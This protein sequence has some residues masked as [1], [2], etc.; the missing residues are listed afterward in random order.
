MNVLISICILKISNVFIRII[1]FT[2]F[3]IDSY[4]HIYISYLRKERIKKKKKKKNNNNKKKS[5]IQYS[6]PHSCGHALIIIF[7]WYNNT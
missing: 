3:K 6:N 7:A 4:I 2:N 1:N 5:Y